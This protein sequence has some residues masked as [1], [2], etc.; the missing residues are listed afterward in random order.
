MHRPSSSYSH[1]LDPANPVN[2][3]C[4]S[5]Q[6]PDLQT[7]LFSC[8]QIQQ[9]NSNGDYQYHIEKQCHHNLKHFSYS[10]SYLLPH[11]LSGLTRA[12]TR[13]AANP[14]MITPKIT[15]PFHSLSA[16]L[17]LR[18]SFV[19]HSLLSAYTPYFFGFGSTW[20]SHQFTNN[21]MRIQ[22]TKIVPIMQMSIMPLYLLNLF[23]NRFLFYHHSV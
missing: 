10:S 6:I 9:I 17:S 3:I 7:S 4:Q 2:Q 11:S 16:E 14:A 8:C 22:L 15:I 23:C 21:F 12:Y 20:E 18:K 5:C 1:G 13:Y 19:L